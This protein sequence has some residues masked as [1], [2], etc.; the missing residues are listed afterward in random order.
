MRARATLAVTGIAVFL[1]VLV[2]SAGAGADGSRPAAAQVGPANGCPKPTVS[3]RLAAGRA[4]RLPQGTMTTTGTIS[5]S[6]R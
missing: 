3:P 6:A 1:I 4:R 2:A 5:S